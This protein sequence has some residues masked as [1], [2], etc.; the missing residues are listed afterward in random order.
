MSLSHEDLRILLCDLGRHVQASV[1]AGR[2]ASSVDALA[3][4]AAQTSA[5]TIYAI[6][7]IG[8]VAIAAWFNEKW[9]ATEPVEV[10]MEGLEEE[11]CFPSGTPIAQTK[12]KCLLDPI[13]GTRCIMYD[14]RSAWSLAALAPQHGPETMLSHVVVA[15]MTELPTTKQ[16]RADQISAVRGCGLVAESTNIFTGAKSPLVLTPSTARDFR[17]GF[18]WMAKYF[19]EG[20]TLTAQIEEQLWAELVGIGVDASPTVFD[21]QYICTG[22]AFYELLVGHDRLVAD[23]RPL[24]YATLDLELSLL[25]HPYD[26]GAA[27]L[28]EEAGIVYEHPLGGFPDAP[29]DTTS[30]VAWIAYANPVLA[31][32]ARPALQKI[33]RQFLG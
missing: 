27:L 29:M 12:W 2:Q 28:L 6:D 9:P 33:L 11:T 17:H 30:G 22:G 14:K 21:D 32:A 20:R 26:V 8:E 15:A 19:P 4:V 5:D 31:S 23:L 13:D 1:L 24:V 16:W 7:K 25:C 18:A 3:Q 10:V